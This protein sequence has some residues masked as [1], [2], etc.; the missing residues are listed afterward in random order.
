MP[1]P[2]LGKKRQCPSCSA[3]FYDMRRSPIVCP[4]CGAQFEA[5]MITRAKRSRSKPKPEAEEPEAAESE[6]EET[7]TAAEEEE[8]YEDV[9]EDADE[10]GEDD[11]SEV[12]GGEDEDER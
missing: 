7:G 10:L 4:S 1:K 8:D 11:L 9:I 5:D 6:V 12:V 2:E 3:R